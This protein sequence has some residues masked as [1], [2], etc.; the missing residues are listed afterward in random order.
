MLPPGAEVWALDADAIIV[1]PGPRLV[2]GVAAIAAILHP[3]RAGRRPP[4]AARRI[5]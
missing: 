5:A 4:G 1:R 3:E 2:E